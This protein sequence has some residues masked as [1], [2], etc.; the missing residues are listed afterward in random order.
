MTDESHSRVCWECGRKLRTSASGGY[1]FR[2]KRVGDADVRVHHECFDEKRAD[3]KRH[4]IEE[5]SR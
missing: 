4:A 5:N 1:S 2:L 3:D